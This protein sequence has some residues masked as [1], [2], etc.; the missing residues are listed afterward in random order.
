[1]AAPTSSLNEMY[2]CFGLVG[3]V[4]SKID[5]AKSYSTKEKSVI[6]RGLASYLNH[7]DNKLITP[8]LSTLYNGNKKQVT[9]MKKIFERQQTSFTSHLN[10]RY[11]EKKIARDYLSAIR[12]CEKKTESRSSFL[13]QAL[14]IMSKR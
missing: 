13:Q 7:L 12:E 14:R 10:A 3:F 6:R 8:Q 9:M 11:S 2:S 1:M 4:D 5:G